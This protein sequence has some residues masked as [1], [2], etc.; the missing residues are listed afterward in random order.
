[1]NEKERYQ[2]ICMF[3]LREGEWVIK[4]HVQVRVSGSS[5]IM[6]QRGW[7]DHQK[8]CSREG[9]WV[10]K[11]HVHKRL[12]GSSR[13]M[14]KRGWVSHQHSCSKEG[15]R[16]SGSS[17]VMFKRGWVGVIKN[18]VQMRVIGISSH[19]QERMSESSRVMFKGGQVDHQ[20]SCLWEV[21]GL[22]LF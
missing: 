2:L 22:Y 18:H 10:I 15:E 12:S 4:S 3:K 5:I 20:Q 17:R 8:L 11:N 1:M 9:E 21:C 19:V 6:F 13:V 16:V 7:V 14:Y